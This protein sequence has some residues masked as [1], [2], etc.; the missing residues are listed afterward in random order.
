MRVEN[1]SIKEELK[2]LKDRE[3]IILKMRFFYGKTQMEVADEE[4]HK[5]RYQELK[6]MP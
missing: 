6:K 5:R 2:K 1:I 3:K 4:Y